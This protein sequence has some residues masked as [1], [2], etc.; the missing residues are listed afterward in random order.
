MR[1][2]TGTEAITIEDSL[3]VGHVEKA[4]ELWAIK[5][6]DING[7]GPEVYYVKYADG[8]YW[9]I[10]GNEDF[11]SK[12]DREVRDWLRIRVRGVDTIVDNA[13][14]D[15]CLSIQTAVGQTDGGYAGIFFSGDNATA[16]LRQYVLDE[17]EQLEEIAP[18]PE[19]FSQVINEDNE[20]EVTFDGK[21]FSYHISSTSVIELHG[22]CIKLGIEEEHFA[23]VVEFWLTELHATSKPI[24]QVFMGAEEYE[25]LDS[26]KGLVSTVQNYLKFT[27]IF[28][29][30][31][32]ANHA[33]E[34]LIA[35]EIPTYY[36]GVELK[37]KSVVIS[38]VQKGEKNV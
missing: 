20:V 4:V 13:L 31:I 1:K 3:A 18:E 29:T 14:N 7:Y 9:T 10:L 37:G 15:A 19:L 21:S 25:W 28:D 33:Y 26:S 27:A 36:K 22:E 16:F 17:M 6:D 34:E 35:T 5:S 12:D 38:L 11:M 24:Y 30:G 23:E 8:N 32:N 2:I